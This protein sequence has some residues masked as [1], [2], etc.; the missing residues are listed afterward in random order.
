MSLVV[1][2]FLAMTIGPSITA[3]ARPAATFLGVQLVVALL[4]HQELAAVPLVMQWLISAPAIVAAAVLAGLETAAKH[5]P[6]IAAILRD[7]QVDNVTG[8]FGAFSAALLFAALGMPEAEAAALVDG[9]ADPMNDPLDGPNGDSE[10]GGVLGAVATAAASEHRMEVQTAAVGLGLGLN[11]GLTWLRSQFLEFIDDFELG[12]M[13]ARIE[14]GGVVGVL[15]LLP[16]LPLVAFGFLVFWTALLVIVAL[17][18]RAAQ[19]VADR[20][21]RVPCENCDYQVREEASLCPKCK[22][23]RQPITE[24]ASGVGAAWRALRTTQKASV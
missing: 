16:L 8:A 22:T 24:P 21:A 9:A 2:R 6:D 23:E 13:W 18:A 15:I 14:T 1:L 17:A 20:R 19:R 3:A 5:D 10:T 11:L 4:V 7:M 12:R